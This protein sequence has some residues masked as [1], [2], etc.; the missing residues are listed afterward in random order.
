MPQNKG[1]DPC[2]FPPLPLSPLCLCLSPATCPSPAMCPTMTCP[3]CCLPSPVS[4]LLPLA[5]PGTYPLSLV[6]ACLVLTHPAACLPHPLPPCL[7]PYPCYLFSPVPHSLLP[8]A[9]YLLGS[10]S[11]SRAVSSSRPGPSPNWPGRSNSSSSRSIWVRAGWAK[12]AARG[13]GKQQRVG[14]PV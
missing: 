1:P 5:C 11:G 7:C 13:E 4:A 2:S 6:C 8:P 12:A 9:T 14:G 10:S 3:P